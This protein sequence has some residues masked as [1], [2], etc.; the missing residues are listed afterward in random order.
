MKNDLRQITLAATIAL[1]LS[2]A[3]TA[4][5]QS[6]AKR[7]EPAK[8][9]AL[10]LKATGNQS[11]V[12]RIGADQSLKIRLV[13]KGRRASFDLLDAENT[14]LSEGTDGRELEMTTAVAGDYR[15]NIQAPKGVAFTLKISI[16]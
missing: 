9:G 15:L 12:F 2:L 16:K 10:S 14:E 7:L 11:Y 5:G 13:S 4:F 8:Q 1:I 6:R 3:V